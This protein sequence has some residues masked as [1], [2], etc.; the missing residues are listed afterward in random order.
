[1]VD[2][3]DT[4]DQQKINVY[5]LFLPEDRKEFLEL[6]ALEDD[7]R[8]KENF[9]PEYLKQIA[10]DISNIRD[11]SNTLRNLDLELQRYKGGTKIHLIPNLRSITL[12]CYRQM[13]EGEMS[14]CPIELAMTNPE[15]FG[16]IIR[17]IHK[18]RHKL[19]IKT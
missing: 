10:R 8:Y 1:M 17:T 16:V 14:K 2:Y 13:Q 5:D 3:Q 9:Y 12:E 15:Y 6:I 19:D 18:A 11:L 7:R 4:E